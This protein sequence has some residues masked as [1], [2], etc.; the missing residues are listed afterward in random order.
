MSK[1]IVFSFCFCYY[2]GEK[3]TFARRK[4]IWFNIYV[5]KKIDFLNIYEYTIFKGK[6][7]ANGD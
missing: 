5:H 3:R 7:V 4:I 1:F 2:K 6:E